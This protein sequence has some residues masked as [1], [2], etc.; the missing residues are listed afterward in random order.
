MSREHVIEHLA[1]ENN[2]LKLEVDRLTKKLEAYQ[3][4]LGYVGN[5]DEKDDNQ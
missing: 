4:I 5:S 1:E 2:R 3:K